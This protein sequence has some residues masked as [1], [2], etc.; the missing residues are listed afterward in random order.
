MRIG[1]TLTMAL[2]CDMRKSERETH[3]EREREREMQK[4]RKMLKVIYI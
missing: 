1:I 3:I 4:G 2:K